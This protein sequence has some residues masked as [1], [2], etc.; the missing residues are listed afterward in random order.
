M[1][2][3][4]VCTR[5]ILSLWPIAS[6]VIH[7][8]LICRS[9]TARGNQLIRASTAKSSCCHLRKRKSMIMWC[10]DSRKMSLVNPLH[11]LVS[12]RSSLICVPSQGRQG[13]F[14]GACGIMWATLLTRR[15]RW[16]T[17]L[18]HQT[19]PV[20]IPKKC[21]FSS[22]VLNL[23]ATMAQ[24]NSI[25]ATAVLKH[26]MIHLVKN[27]SIKWHSVVFLTVGVIQCFTLFMLNMSV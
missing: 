5:S 18:R 19:L 3:V 25:L 21:T 20:R 17:M 6:K 12:N 13:M 23:H 24:V 2:T 15:R 7:I 14:K 1:L 8:G 16:R 9:S 4:I 11:V 22:L 26:P 27:S 10:I